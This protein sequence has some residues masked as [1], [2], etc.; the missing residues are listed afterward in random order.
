MSMFLT[1]SGLIGDWV[2]ATAS[3]KLGSSTPF[4]PADYEYVKVPLTGRSHSW[5]TDMTSVPYEK[6]TSMIS[7]TSVEITVPT[8]G[9]GYFTSSGYVTASGYAGE[10]RLYSAGP[11]DDNN[12]YW[13]VAVSNPPQQYMVEN[14]CH[15]GMG[16]ITARYKY[17]WD[18]ENN[19]KLQ[20]ISEAPYVQSAQY[21]TLYESGRF[22]RDPFTHRL[23]VTTS[24][25]E[26]VYVTS[27]IPIIGHALYSRAWD[28]AS[29][30][31]ATYTAYSDHAAFKPLSSEQ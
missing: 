19:N 3:A 24:M 7:P 13:W 11:Y 6:Y 16:K 23:V 8:A 26:L 18:G 20:I 30:S 14:G 15:S 25:S 10:F 22:Y 31:G 2:P 9:T 17:N 29:G 1:N 12:N 4:N 28:T 5:S 21:K 27:D